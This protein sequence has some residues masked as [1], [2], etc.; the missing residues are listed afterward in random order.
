VRAHLRKTPAAPSPRYFRFKLNLTARN[1]P[2][3]SQPNIAAPSRGLMRGAA[4]ENS[5]NSLNGAAAVPHREQQAEVA[6]S[7]AVS[8]AAVQH[9][10][11]VTF[12]L[13][14]HPSSSAPCSASYATSRRAARTTTTRAPPPNAQ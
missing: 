5:L 4:G 10:F 2:V 11:V 14:L 6:A 3:R 13:S 9:L 8:A 12:V 1:Q 7:R